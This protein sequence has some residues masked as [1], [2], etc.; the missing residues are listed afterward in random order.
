MLYRVDKKSNQNKL[1]AIEYNL[2]QRASRISKPSTYSAGL[3]LPKNE[4]RSV[5]QKQ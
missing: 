2:P 3:V 5:T 1:Y 4:K